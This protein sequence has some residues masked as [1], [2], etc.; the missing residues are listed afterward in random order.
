MSNLAIEAHGVHKAYT[1][2][3]H[4]RRVALD[5]VSLTVQHGASFG[6]VGPRGSG[7]TTL[8]KILASRMQPDSGTVTR[9]LR[10]LYFTGNL[11]DSLGKIGDAASRILVLDEPLAPIGLVARRETLALLGKLHAE[12]ATILL[13]SRELSSIEQLCTTGDIAIL[14]RGKVLATGK[15][16]DLRAARGCRVRVAS[17]PEHLQHTLAASG[18]F[19]SLTATHCWVASPDRSQLN[20]LIDHLRSA[21]IAIEGIDRLFPTLE[22]IYLG[23]GVQPPPLTDRLGRLW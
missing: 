1:S 6:I 2:L 14:H 5:G 22:Q 15:T 18:F 12:G 17:L 10:A 8:L 16:T 7:K 3:W 23:T 19:V 13:A 9:S 4:A 21:G 11:L 20:R